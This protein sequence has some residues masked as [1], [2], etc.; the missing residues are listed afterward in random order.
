[1]LVCKGDVTDCRHCNRSEA[2]Y[3]SVN[4]QGSE[5]TEAVLV[6][7]VMCSSSPEACCNSKESKSTKS[8]MDLF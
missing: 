6:Q 5:T 7:Q 2:V 3:Y 4:S 8:M 1:M